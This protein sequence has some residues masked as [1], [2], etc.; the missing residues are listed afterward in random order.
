MSL[1]IVEEIKKYYA[2][3]IMKDNEYINIIPEKYIDYEMRQISFDDIPINTD[4][5]IIHSSLYD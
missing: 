5:D 2:C 1:V 3:R 4:A